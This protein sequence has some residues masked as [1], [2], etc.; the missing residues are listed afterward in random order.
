VVTAAL[1][2]LALQRLGI[3]ARTFDA[4]QAGLR[5]DGPPGLARLRCVRRKPL[6]TALCD[7]QVPVVTGF[8][9]AD[10]GTIRTLGRGGSDVTAVAIAAAFAASACRFYKLHGL[11][12]ADPGFDPGAVPIGTTGYAGLHRLLTAGNTLLHP[13]A[14]HAAERFGLR[15]EFEEFPGTGA[16]SV[17]TPVGTGLG[18][19][20]TSG[21]PQAHRHVPGGAAAGAPSP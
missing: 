3:P 11:R 7:G 6:R 20:P 19:V 1:V 16:T 9:V 17:V 2:T 14:A 5:G 12:S 13:D 15:L 4:Q 10:R 21:T 8:Q 18:P